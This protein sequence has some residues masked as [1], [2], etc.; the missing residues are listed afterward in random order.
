[1]YLGNG[2]TKNIFNLL[3]A[4][5]TGLLNAKETRDSDDLIYQ[6]TAKE[7]RMRNETATKFISRMKETKWRHFKV[8]NVKLAVAKETRQSP[9]VSD[10]QPKVT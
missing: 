5:E 7:L 2:T 6:T 10:R 3:N 9:E 4:K 1:M 8:E